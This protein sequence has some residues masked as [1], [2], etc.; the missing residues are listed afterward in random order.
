[1]AW[2]WAQGGMDLPE[3]SQSDLK[4]H[5]SPETFVVTTALPLNVCILT[6]CDAGCKVFILQTALRFNNLNLTMGFQEL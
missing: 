6:M 5:S 2:E 1:M 4:S 3:R